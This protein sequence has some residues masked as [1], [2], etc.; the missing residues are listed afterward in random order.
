MDYIQSL[1]PSNDN[2]HFVRGDF[3]EVSSLPET[4]VVVIGTFKIGI[5]HGHQ[6]VP[7]GDQES[8]SAIQRE[9]DCDILISGQT[10]KSDISK[11]DGKYFINPGSATGSYSALNS[12]NTASFV[13]MQMQTE[14]VSCFLYELRGDDLN[15]SK[16]ELNKL[17]DADLNEEQ[18]EDG[19]DNE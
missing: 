8:L 11:Y 5:I 19:K 16:V 2:A 3:D 13:V 15:V 12:T 6:I 7:W 9:L 18:E 17:T 1:A 4:K 10:H 14:S